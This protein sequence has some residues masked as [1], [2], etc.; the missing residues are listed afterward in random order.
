MAPSPAFS[1]TDR[2][3][4][5]SR[6]LGLA[7]LCAERMPPDLLNKLAATMALW[8]DHHSPGAGYA[9]HMAQELAQEWRERVRPPHP[10]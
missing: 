8:L 3:Q 7:T 2:H 5:R 9:Q 4:A 6:Y 10:N 1:D